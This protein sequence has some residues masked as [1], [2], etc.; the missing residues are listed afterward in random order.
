MR[1]SHVIPQDG[2]LFTETA[3]TKNEQ[4]RDT[5]KLIFPSIDKLSL[6]SPKLYAVLLEYLSDAHSLTTENNIAKNISS[7]FFK[8]TL[9]AAAGC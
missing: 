8:E 1:L 2:I 9:S 3:R 4:L 7:F 6:N 5:A